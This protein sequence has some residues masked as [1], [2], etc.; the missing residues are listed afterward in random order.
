M[1]ISREYRERSNHAF[2]ALESHVIYE[3]EVL[4]EDVLHFTSRII[5]LAP[6]RIHCFHAMSRGRGG[7]RA[8]INE[9]M[10]LHMDLAQR[11]S[12]PMPADAEARV[13][14]VFEVHAQLPAP[15]EAGRGIRLHRAPAG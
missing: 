1:D 7:P 6:R 14:K 8:A 4:P 3:Q 13:R 12:V 11:R 5:G 2:F 9:V 15:P 10:Y